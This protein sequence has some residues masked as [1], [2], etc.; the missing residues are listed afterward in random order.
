MIAVAKKPIYSTHK[1]I[2]N[3]YRRPETQNNTRLENGINGTSVRIRI[4]NMIENSSI[5]CKP[6]FVCSLTVGVVYMIA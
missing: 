5:A 4:R 6:S 2:A 3:V 1:I